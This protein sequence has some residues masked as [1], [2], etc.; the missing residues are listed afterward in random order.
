MSSGAVSQ[1]TN[2]DGK[3][4]VDAIDYARAQA[5]AAQRDHA[6]GTPAV[7]A[8]LIPGFEILKEI[9]R[10]GQGVVYE[11]TQTRTRRRV[12]LK[13]MRGGASAGD[14]ERIRFEREAMVLAQ[15]QHPNIVRLYEGGAVDGCLYYA[16]D[17]VEGLPFDAYVRQAKC[18]LR[19]ILNLM[20]KIAGAVHAAHLKGIVHRDLEPS[21]IRIGD[22]G[23]PHLLDFG[24]AK[25]LRVDVAMQDQ[26][27]VTTTGQFMGS[28]P[29]AAPEQVDGSPDGVD[30]RTD[31]YA[32][33]LLL[34]RALTGQ[35]PYDVVGPVRRVMDNIVHSEPPRPSALRSTVDD[36]VDTV[37][38]KCLQ[39]DPERRYQIAGALQK[40]IEHYLD[41]KPIDAKRDS[42]LYVLRMALRRYRRLTILSV[43]SG[44][45]I[46]GFAIA[47]FVL[48]GRIRDE[49]DAS[50]R[51][52]RELMVETARSEI[53][54]G[55]A[56]RATD[57]L[58]R[59]HLNQ[60][61]DDGVGAPLEFRWALWELYDR[62]PCLATWQAHA[63]WLGGLFFSSDGTRL[64]S[65]GRIDA[66][67]KYW[68][69]RNGKL[70]SQTALSRCSGQSIVS[71]SP[72]GAWLA[73]GC[74]D[75]SIRLRNIEGG[76]QDLILEGQKG[77]IRT[78]A[79]TPNGDRMISG[80]ADGSLRI[81]DVQS[82][83]NIGDLEEHATSIASLAMDSTGDLLASFDQSG[84]VNIWSLSQREL[85]ST[86]EPPPRSVDAS[87]GYSIDV[88][89]TMVAIGL[90]LGVYTWDFG[91]D[92]KRKLYDHTDAVM[93]VRFSPSGKYLASASRDR[94]INVWDLDRG[95]IHQIFKGNDALPRRVLFSPDEK[96]I[97]AGLE[98]GAIKLWQTQ[99]QPALTRLEHS[100]TVHCAR[101]SP[102][103]K[104][105][106]SSGY[107]QQPRIR[108]WDASSHQLLQELEGHESVIAAV[109]VHP[110]G[111]RIASAGYDGSLREWIVPKGTCSR[112]EKQAHPSRINCVAYSPDGA[113]MATGGDDGVVRLWNA[114]TLSQIHEFHGGQ[115]RI[116][117]LSF[118]PDGKSLA[119]CDWQGG[120]IRV[121][122][123]ETFQT[124]Y[125]RE[126]NGSGARVVCFSPDGQRLASAGDD[127]SIS[128][129]D[130]A[131]G[132]LLRSWEAHT[133]DI[134]AMTF[135][136]SGRMLASAGRG[137]QIRLWDTS[138]P[139][140]ILLATLEGHDDMVLSLAFDPNGNTLASGSRDRSIGLWDLTYY[141][142]H[143]YGN[144][145]A[146]I[147]RIGLPNCDHATV[148]SLRARAADFAAGP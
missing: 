102:D 118:S 37:V 125:F 48:A 14:I 68:D 15:F 83:Q 56:V 18:S 27:S 86:L 50:R 110:D 139:S 126:A 24:L 10:G 143:I 5:G 94:S 67:L 63:G 109:A 7:P 66:M 80:S 121:H 34:F 131:T 85:R 54:F 64:A 95:V 49:R 57:M 130:A 100:G 19:D 17:F 116:P 65:V 140:G 114:D 141:D 104:Y 133:F 117:S 71:F 13:V 106:I 99:R 62:Q 138:S 96:M 76:S 75:G 90:D 105:L 87:T 124:R 89:G 38:L 6:T 36:D 35:P 98:N 119:S 147:E 16:M 129:W 127:R 73:L 77:P 82:G 2:D 52:N 120:A 103:G 72:N 28:L 8:V 21:N 25:L 45:A 58:W 30:I 26:H 81:W 33:G 107:E 113:R 135:H 32:L 53:R 55:D 93:Y 123:L 23:E 112:I 40:D 4:P 43:A 11:A 137:S 70:V 60:L 51:L 44:L 78:I 145:E 134:F 111:K 9:H 91:T 136:P 31:V 22:D 88:H 42:T 61:P 69:P 97:A 122:D 1:Q 47:M 39:K 12:A 29:W 92:E 46:T 144:L 132:A 41:G 142:R 3:Q 146:Q 115:R 108:V 128:I 101:F 79:F 148:E 20:G 74:D 59:V 84:L